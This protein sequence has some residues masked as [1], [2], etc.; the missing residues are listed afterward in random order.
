[1]TRTLL[2]PFVFASLVVIS[3]LGCEARVSLGGDC[4]YHSECG[5]LRCLYGRCRAECVEDVDCDGAQVCNSGVCATPDESCSEGDPCTDPELACAGS[6]CTQRC[7]ADRS[8]FGESVCEDRVG[9]SVCVPRDLPDAGARADAGVDAATTELDANVEMLD[10]AGTTDT[11]R[12]PADVPLRDAFASPTLV[13]DLCVGRYFACLVQRGPGRVLCWGVGHTGELGGGEPLVEGQPGVIPCTPDGATAL[14]SINLVPVVDSRDADLTSVRSVYC[15]ERTALALTAD[16]TLYSWGQGANG[17]LGRDFPPEGSFDASARPVT[18]RADVAILGVT[19]ATFGSRHAC[20][21]RGGEMHCWGAQYDGDH[22]QLGTDT[23]GM[24]YMPG[25]VR[26]D[27]FTSVRAAAVTDL[28]TC[29]IDTEGFVSCAGLNESAAMGSTASVTTAIRTP[30]ELLSV[31][32][33]A[34]SLVT[35]PQFVC[36]LVGN[37]P[38]CWG[39]A[40]EGS[41]GRDDVART[42]GTCPDGMGEGYCDPVAARVD[43]ALSFDAIA[44]GAYSSTVCGLS[45]GR[46]Y[47]WGASE[48]GTAGSD[49]RVYVPRDPIRIEGGGILED[50]R[51]VRVGGSTA[52]ALTTADELYCWGSNQSGHLRMAPDTAVHREAVR[53]PTD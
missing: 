35:G 30:M 37:T 28:G 2:A 46:V 19:G 53:V 14:C 11:A 42:L 27:A 52:C 38:Y 24:T 1:M 41:L 25:A 6:I 8:C 23:T 26:A 13:D 18:D 22:G 10:A 36:A 45:G 21:W 17:Q 3:A 12:I 20:A 43:S 5:A 15:G 48:R 49:L 40:G 4:T 7:E 16:G 51:L 31:P 9:G 47:C 34:S 50:V 44:S 29:V 33:G 32:A 39:Q